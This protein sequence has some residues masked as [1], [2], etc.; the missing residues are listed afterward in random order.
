MD[1][2]KALPT[3]SLLKSKRKHAQLRQVSL[4]LP[5]HYA[6]RS[7]ELMRAFSIELKSRERSC[8]GFVFVVGGNVLFGQHMEQKWLKTTS[9]A[10]MAG[11]ILW[12][13][14]ASLSHVRSFSM[15]W[16]VAK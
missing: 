1:G 3:L 11:L 13:L 14:C 12:F 16:R 2:I 15:C 9:R 10:S 8:F 5:L 4:A 6:A 7:M